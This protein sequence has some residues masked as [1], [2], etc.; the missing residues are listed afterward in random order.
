[1]YNDG[2]S[3]VT[4]NY[5]NDVPPYYTPSTVPR[6]KYSPISSS[7]S[8]SVVA[9]NNNHSKI[10][11]RW[12]VVAVSAAA[13]VAVIAAVVGYVY[14]R[15]HQ[16]HKLSAEYLRAANIDVGQDPTA[17]LANRL[18]NSDCIDNAMNQIDSSN[19]AAAES[20][21]NA[22]PN[23]TSF[24]P[25]VLAAASAQR[26]ATSSVVSAGAATNRNRRRQNMAKKAPPAVREPN[27]DDDDDEN[28]TTSGDKIVSSKSRMGMIHNAKICK[29]ETPTM[30]PA[31]RRRTNDTF[32]TQEEADRREQIRVEGQQQDER[33]L[34][35]RQR[36][37]EIKHRHM[38]QHKKQNS[39]GAFDD[40]LK[41]EERD[42][43]VEDEH[44]Q[45]VVVS[46]PPATK[47][48]PAH[49]PVHYGGSKN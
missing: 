35:S 2:P 41:E 25:A 26:S 17:S 37:A 13:L 48:R 42:L 4:N 44:G 12:K 24:K 46:R 47:L 36:A 45:E 28:T 23:N 8:S 34:A 5:N 16:H 10:S 7:S 49:R 29:Q 9:G 43:I 32:I 18:A 30:P 11:L 1:M 21:A 3:I 15:R 33:L 22:H 27:D 40:F 38:E 6:V 39:P 31:I 19:F 14:Y 20:A